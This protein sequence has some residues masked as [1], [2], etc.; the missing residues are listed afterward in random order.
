MRRSVA[1]PLVLIVAGALFLWNNLRPDIPIWDLVSQY[2]PFLLIAWGLLQL[3]EIGAAAVANRPVPRGMGPGSLVL[4]ILICLI[5]SG[6]F[7]VHNRGWRI[8]PGRLEMFGEQYDYPVNQQTSVGG[9]RRIVFQNM[10]GNLRI[11][12]AGAQEIR[13]A[14]RKTVRA[15]HKRDADQ[16][17]RD[18]PIEITT[19]G[20]HVIVRGNQGHVSGD[21]RVSADLEITV[22]RPFAVEAHGRSGD[23]D[24]TDLA[25]DVDISSDHGDVRLTNLAGNSRVSL[26]HSDLIRAS[27]LKGNLD[28]EGR[29]SDVQLENVAGQVTI[30]GSYSGTLNFRNLAKPLH[31]ASQNTDLSV[32]ALPGQINM[33][34]GEFTARNLVGPIRLKTRTKDVKIE[35]FTQSLE[36]QTESGDIA[37]DPARTPLPRIDAKTRT[38]KIELALPEKAPFQLVATTERGEVMNDF[39]PP[40]E[41]ESR[42]RASSLRGG[43]GTGPEIS[44]STARGSVLVRKS[45]VTEAEATPKPA[46]PQKPE[47][48]APPPTP[49]P[50][51]F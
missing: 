16:A 29:G 49:A 23:V 44:V 38:G 3:V 43:M 46:P 21:R 4:V 30:N 28:L 13:I 10:R 14:G 26:R 15:F 45:G 37:I 35:D 18:T 33:D 48:P 6:L 40:I 36:L 51:K 12:G 41:K 31:F 25:G 27:G 22:P 34:L 39:G 20:D 47:P 32:E 17:D 9:A 2:W 50:E 8:A 11:T 5:G 24:V 42:G 7:F 1:G 19:E